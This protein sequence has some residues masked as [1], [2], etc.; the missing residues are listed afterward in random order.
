MILFILGE[1]CIEESSGI[2]N[3]IE[4]QLVRVESILY[5]NKM[6]KSA[7]EVQNIQICD[8]NVNRNFVLPLYMVFPR[9]FSCPTIN[10][11]P[12]YKI[13]FEVN[14]II[15]F[16]DGCTITENFPIVVFRDL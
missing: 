4:L 7:S 12:N 5:E 9:I 16:S 14:L 6:L 13:E 10:I 11:N 8:G 15:V 1:V 2:I 3:S